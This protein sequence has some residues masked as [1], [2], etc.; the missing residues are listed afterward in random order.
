MLINNTDL[1][2]ILPVAKSLDFVKM[3][4]DIKR[5]QR[6]FIRPILGK[7]LESILE[8]AYAGT[9]TDPQQELIDMI[10]P[11]LAYLAVWMYIPKGNIS[12]NS[13]GLQS[14]HSESL[15]PAFEW[16]VKQYRQSMLKDGYNA[17]DELIAHLED[18][19]NTD[20]P[21]WLNS[22]GCTLAR[23][24][25]INSADEFTGFVNKL[26]GSRYQFS[27]LIPILSRIEKQLLPSLI[28]TELYDAIKAEIK[29]DNLTAAN[30]ALL[31]LL[32]G[33][34]SHLSWSSALLEM[35]VVI[36]DEGVHLANSTASGSVDGKVSATATPL[37]KDMRDYHQ[38]LS[39]SYCDDITDLLY[40]NEASY[41][42]WT[43]SA[44]YNP[45]QATVTG[46]VIN[47][48]DSSLFMM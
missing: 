28:S 45:N 38:N 33:A 21:D 15:K 9:P 20:F 7:D 13:Q 22:E 4:G 30:L 24:Y 48:A 12:L 16:Q 8:G 2:I 31:P 5:A 43:G 11:A 3:T 35:G 25:V 42:L 27:Q 44:L 1:K 40:A 10:H 6:N 19:A 26:G 17:L 23:S 32:Q 46:E 29:T 18:V 47:E 39:S 37:V 14:Q 36:D 34:V 41:P